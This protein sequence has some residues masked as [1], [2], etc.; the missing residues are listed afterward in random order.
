MSSLVKPTEVFTHYFGL[1]FKNVRDNIARMNEKQV[2][3]LT[4]SNV[5]ITDFRKLHNTGENFLTESGVYKLIFKSHKPDAEKFQDWVTDEV[6]PAIR[7]HGAYMTEEKI[8]EALLDP[9]TIITLAMQL[10]EERKE[11]ARMQSK[12]DQDKPMVNLAIAVTASNKSI[13]IGDLAKILKQNGIDTGQNRLFDLLR[14]KGYL[15][16]SKAKEN[17]LPTQRS[18]QMGILEIAFIPYTRRDGIK[19]T[20]KKPM[21]TVKGQQYFINKFLG[22]NS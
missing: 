13:E 3:K 4:N 15:T 10:K 17:S 5:G 21:V 7:K 9:D 8:Q 18:L 22:D 11:K 16:K 2:V 19:D 14:K 12:I 20:Y 6:L 1:D